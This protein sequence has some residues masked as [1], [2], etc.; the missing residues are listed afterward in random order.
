MDTKENV[1]LLLG[2]MEAAD[3]ISVGRTTIYGLVERGELKTVRIGRR[4][5][6]TA[7]SLEAYVQR[8]TA[9]ADAA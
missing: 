8:L 5:L 2:Y 4:A 7:E 9:N 1:R 3:K 6:I